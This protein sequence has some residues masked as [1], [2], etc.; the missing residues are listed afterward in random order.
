M[1]VRQG[2]DSVDPLRDESGIFLWNTFGGKDECYVVNTLKQWHCRMGHKNYKDVSHSE[3]QVLGIKISDF[4][5]ENYE[6]C[7]LNKRKK[8]PVP[9]DCYTRATGTLDIVHRD[10]LIPIDPIAEVGID[11][12]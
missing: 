7:E 10:I 11:L 5:I 8:K 4:R 2:N 6:T 12:L 3:L 1:F 9:K